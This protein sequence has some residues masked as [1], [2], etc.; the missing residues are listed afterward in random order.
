MSGVNYLL[1]VYPISSQG[2]PEEH[3]TAARELERQLIIKTYADAMVKVGMNTT[4]AT[5]LAIDYYK[6]TYTP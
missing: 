6:K 2:V 3:A 5:K 4:N 1:S